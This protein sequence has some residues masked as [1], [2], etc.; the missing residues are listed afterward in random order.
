MG[1]AEGSNEGT[2]EVRKKGNGLLNHM[3]TLPIHVMN[4][5]GLEALSDYVENSTLF[6]RLLP[7]ESS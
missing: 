7:W 1:I 5:D 6:S 3:R 4:H 2:P